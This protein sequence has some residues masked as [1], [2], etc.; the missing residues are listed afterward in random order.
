MFK[1]SSQSNHKI[2][3]YT[4]EIYFMEY[5]V[6]QVESSI[7]YAGAIQKVE[8]EVNRLLKEGWSLRGDLQIKTHSDSNYFVVYQVLTK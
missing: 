4:K 7:S 8:T 6:V 1:Q 5:K 3:Y 2:F